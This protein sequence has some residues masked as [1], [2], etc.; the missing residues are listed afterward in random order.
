MQLSRSAIFH[1]NC[2]FIIFLRFDFVLFF[3]PLLLQALLLT[4]FKL[5]VLNFQ[6][7]KIYFLGETKG[8]GR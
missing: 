1:V 2:A 6:Q 7:L 5:K 8:K 4:Q 3:Y